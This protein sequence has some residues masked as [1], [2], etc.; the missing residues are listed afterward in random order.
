[1]VERLVYRM[2][3]AAVMS[4]DMAGLTTVGV[5]IVAWGYVVWYLF[6]RWPR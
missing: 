3:A 5:A 1:M 2:G 6:F 4:I